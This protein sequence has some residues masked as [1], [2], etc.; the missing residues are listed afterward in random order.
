MTKKKE[1]Q[2]NACR[3]LL[4]NQFKPIILGVFATNPGEG[5]VEIIS[6]CCF[7]MSK[8]YL[9]WVQKVTKNHPKTFP[10]FFTTVPN[11]QKDPN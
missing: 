9:K 1:E 10:E 8:M 5:H 2:R 11:E 7:K 6:K 4:L 3:W